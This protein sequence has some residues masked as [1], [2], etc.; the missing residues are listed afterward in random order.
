MQVLAWFYSRM[1]EFLPLIEE[2]KKKLRS[3]DQ[4]ESE[5]EDDD[6]DD[7]DDDELCIEK[8]CDFARF[9]LHSIGI[10]LEGLQYAGRVIKEAN[11]LDRLW[12]KIVCD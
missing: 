11:T 1:D 12:N 4:E 7:D 2:T 5:G 6:D 3:S 10:P 9:S 8:V